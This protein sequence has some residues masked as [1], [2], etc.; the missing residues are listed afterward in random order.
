[1][2]A[3]PSKM[4]FQGLPLI[5]ISLGGVKGILPWKKFRKF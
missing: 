1:M 4:N 2:R 5:L 3:A